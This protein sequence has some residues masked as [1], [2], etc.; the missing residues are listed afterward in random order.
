LQVDLSDESASFDLVCGAVDSFVEECRPFS[1]GSVH[2]IGEQ[3]RTPR[4][5][6]ATRGPSA[7]FHSAKPSTTSVDI[8]TEDVTESS[9]LTKNYMRF[10]N[11]ISLVKSKELDKN[12]FCSSLTPADIQFRSSEGSFLT[13]DQ[14]ASNI[15][16]IVY[17]HA[18]SMSIQNSGTEKKIRKISSIP[19][20]LASFSIIVRVKDFN[21]S[22]MTCVELSLSKPGSN[23]SSRYFIETSCFAELKNVY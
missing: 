5:V 11:S 13:A 12:S 22:V 2:L 1:S 19:I 20:L 23:S 16:H 14:Q 21:P 3:E 17:K 8:D 6:A 4:N 18:A 10:I 15:V 9:P 7:D